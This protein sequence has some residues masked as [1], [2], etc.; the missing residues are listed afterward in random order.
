MR[1]LLVLSTRCIH[2]GLVQLWMMVER[3]LNQWE[4]SWLTHVYNV[5]L[6][7]EGLLVSGLWPP[8]NGLCERMCT[9]NR[10]EVKRYAPYFIP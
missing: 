7:P 10:G 4:P 9:L 2:Y 3:K 5:E 6:E 8:S 1:V